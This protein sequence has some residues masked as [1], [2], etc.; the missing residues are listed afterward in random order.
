MKFDP[1]DHKGRYEKWKKTGLIPGVSKFNSDL[2]IEYL[3]DMENGFNVARVGGISFIRLNN[4]RQRLGFVTAELERLY[5]DKRLIDITDREIVGFFKMMRDGRIKTKKGRR[6]TSV[7]DYAYV[8]KAFWH[9]HQR[10]ENDKGNMVK[11][12]TKY[13]DMNKVKESEFVYFTV[14]EVKKWTQV[15]KYNYKALMW[16]LFDTGI[17]APTELMNIR[18]SDL[19]EMEGSDIYQLKIR[20]E[21]SKT[22]GRT[23]KLLICSKVL[24][25]YINDMNLRGNDYIFTVTPQK[26]NQYLK[27]LALRVSGDLKTKG[28]KSIGQ[29]TLYDFRH[30]SACYWLPRYK[31]ES[32][33]KYR[34]GWKKDQMIHHYTKLLGMSDTIAEQDLVL[35][36]EAKIKT[37]KELEKTQKEKSILEEELDAQKQEI[38]Q[39]KIQ[40]GK[41][42]E[43][44]KL[45]LHLIKKLDEKGRRSE[46]IEIVKEAG[47]ESLG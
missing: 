16:F 7:P 1:Y 45:I 44:D 2:I 3:T 33:L 4:L 10:V 30:S 29:L 40:I 19:S 38:A 17:R 22:F 43:R 28:G 27:R 5:N 25:N 13:I 32:A 20:D 15:A 39:L 34:F 14:E 36:P 26:M 18:V 35:D 42:E 6:Y 21:V 11:D 41:C 8:F 31:S 9:W 47:V 12:I 23:I 46:M 37:E 24:K